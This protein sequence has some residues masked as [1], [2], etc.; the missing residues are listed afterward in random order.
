[1]HFQAHT[2]EVQAMQNHLNAQG[3]LMT[4]PQKLKWAILM[5]AYHRA[6]YPAPTVCAATIEEWWE[7][8]EENELE[9]IAG[10]FGDAMCEFRSSGFETDLPTPYENQA[11]HYEYNEVAAE[12]PDQTWVGWTYYHG[13]GK[14]SDPDGIDWIPGAYFVEMKVEMKPVRVFSL[15][16]TKP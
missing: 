6:G 14:H 13:G 3:A 11:R 1:M 9:H 5:D 2:S 7:K 12:M 10:T 8:A 4:A 16:A 15:K